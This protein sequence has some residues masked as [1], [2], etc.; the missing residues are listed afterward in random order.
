MGQFGTGGGRAR[1]RL[2]EGGGVDEEF[3]T[4]EVVMEKTASQTKD[5]KKYRRKLIV[6]VKTLTCNEQRNS[7]RAGHGGTLVAEAKSIS[8]KQSNKNISGAD[9]VAGDRRDEKN[10]SNEL[11]DA[12]GATLCA[13]DLI[14]RELVVLAIHA[15]LLN[16]SASIGHQS[17][18]RAAH[19]TR[20]ESVREARK[21]RGVGRCERVQYEIR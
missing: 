12:L 15:G 2:G 16:E 10:E 13:H 14:V 18:H 8:A 4:R 5:N 3:A 20:E 6:T 21:R 1:Q 17:R 19:V 11:A 9:R 7:E